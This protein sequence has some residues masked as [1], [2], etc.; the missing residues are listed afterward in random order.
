MYNYNSSF[1]FNCKFLK[2]ICYLSIMTF[3][4]NILCKAVYLDTLFTKDSK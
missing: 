4:F 2:L 3:I 1:V